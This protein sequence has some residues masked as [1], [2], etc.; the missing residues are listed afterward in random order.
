MSE[1]IPGAGHNKAKI[2]VEISAAGLGLV[3]VG[4]AGYLVY[5][6]RKEVQRDIS[7]VDTDKY[8][9]AFKIFTNE[10]VDA[11]LPHGRELMA[12][13]AVR[14]FYASRSSTEEVITKAE[15]LEQLQEHEELVVT[16]HRLQ[17]ALSFLSDKEQSLISRRPQASNPKSS[18]YFALP[19]LEWGMEYGDKPEILAM[20][21]DDFMSG[22]L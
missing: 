15:L 2:A 7:E 16:G 21:E 4:A 20:A 22:Q 10:K 17:K 5:K 1:H 19:A 18:G 9:E 14:I 8:V 11:V 3:A 6:N 12:A 13:A